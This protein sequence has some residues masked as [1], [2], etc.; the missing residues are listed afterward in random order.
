MI[1]AAVPKDEAVLEAFLLRHVDG[2][3]FPLSNLRDQGLGEGDFASAH[4]HAT[5]FWIDGD[6]I[7]GILALTRGGM[8]LPMLPNGFDAGAFVPVLADMDLTGAVGP[9]GQ[10]RRLL[11]G[12]GLAGRPAVVDR[13]EPGFAL[14]LASLRIPAADGAKLIPVG[15]DY[16]ALLVDW[17]ADYHRTTLGTPEDQ[18]ADR[19]AGDIDNCIANGRH[20]VLLLNGQPVAMTG[21][22]AALPEI[23]QIGGVYTPPALRN[24]GYARL[25]LALHLAEAR[26]KGVARA[27]LF[28]ASEAAS[29]A[30]LSI[31]FQP[32]QPVALVL[33]DGA[34]RVRP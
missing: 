24:R 5:R 4:P 8:L 27:V 11:T 26:A 19:A 3:M 10:V 15:A 28:A 22:N 25:A 23:V 12:L 16:R 7:G 14:D 13:D 33:F 2:A 29:R 31:G 30:Y 32:S 34:Q 17:R 21:F 9:A 18:V 20:R 1:R 6:P